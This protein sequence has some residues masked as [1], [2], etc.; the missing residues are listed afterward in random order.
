M[1]KK[2]F[3][4]FCFILF[5]A[6]NSLAS[7]LELEWQHYISEPSLKT[8]L[9]DYVFLRWDQK[10]DFN[11]G[12]L[13]FDSHVQMEYGLDRSDFF[14]FNIPE[15]YFSYEYNFKKPFYSIESIELNVGRKIKDWNL[16]DEYWEM[17]SWNP[18]SRWNPLHP[19]TS[20]LTGAFLTFMSSQWS[21]DFFLG[22]LFFPNQEVQLIE[23]DGEIYSNSRW[24]YPLPDK[25]L[26]DRASELDIDINY[27]IYSPHIF[28]ILFQP[29]YVLSLKTWSK[30]PEA[31]YW[32]RWS[33]ADK[34]VNHLF[35]VLNNK[36]RYKVGKEKGAVGKVH[37]A[38]TSL[39]VRQ[40][41]LSAEWGLDYGD[42]STVFTLENTKMK[43]VD[44]SP[45]GWDFLN[46]RENFTYFS[47]LLKY[48]VLSN[49]F[50]QLAYIQTWFK[51]YNV[52]TVNPAEV[53]PPSVLQRYKVLE[54]MGVDWETEFLS[55]QGLPRIFALNYRYSFLGRGAWL[56]VKT[57]YHFTPQI[58]T[59][60]TFD[61]L[62]A[63]NGA[64]YLLSRSR[65][66]DYFSWRLAY[67][68]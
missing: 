22:A 37:Q 45:E 7:Q 25:A 48:N 20:G 68:F 53:K 8:Q 64:L 62:G 18:L 19:V 50:V 54:G 23:K 10:T 66:N 47:A 30:T 24:F 41:L 15:L 36:E 5:Y 32:M 28:D 42:L 3:C 27:F 11:Y 65:H 60:M 63:K 59:A 55:S 1:S 26:P 17:G 13:Y 35:Y 61:V 14:Y 34:P 58:H 40:R 2:I 38:I 4:F 6:F 46:R 52:G 12:A 9:Q 29:S 49:S 21:V 33:I 39:P 51:N 57:S 44:I 67:D 43:E 56:F 16:A 31:Y